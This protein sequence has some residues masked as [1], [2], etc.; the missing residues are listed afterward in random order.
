MWHRR[1]CHHQACPVTLI[2]ILT[3]L[4]QGIDGQYGE[5]VVGF[6]IF[7]PTSVT[8][9]RGLC[10]YIP[11]TFIIGASFEDKL[12]SSS[13]GIWYRDGS[14]VI[15]ATN[16]INKDVS[17]D[18]K[19]RFLLTGNVGK[20]DCSFSI[21]DAQWEDQRGYRFRLE[22]TGSLMFSFKG[23][24]P[25]V[26]VIELTEKPEI[27]NMTL[28]AG[29]MVTLSCTAPGTCNGTTPDITWVG[30]V[31]GVNNTYRVQ[32]PDGNNTFISNITFT[33]SVEDHNSLL[34]CT[35][36][37]RSLGYPTTNNTITLNVEYKPSIKI[38]IPGNSNETV[39]I[40]V[41]EG[42]SQSLQ[43]TVNSNPNSTII[44][45]KKDKEIK[46]IKSGQ[47]LSLVL[48]NISLSDA[49]VYSCT[50]EN[51]YGKVIKTITIAMEYAPRR[52]EIH[53]LNSNEESFNKNSTLDILEGSPLSLMCSANSN[54]LAEYQWLKYNQT[55]SIASKNSQLTISSV[56][57]H[58]KGLY[59]CE[60]TNKYGN[61]TSSI[62]IIVKYEG[63]NLGL[64][65]GVSCGAILIILLIILA[66]LITK[67]FRKRS[68]LAKEE[69]TKSLHMNEVIYSNT[70]L[71][72]DSAQR[73][74]MAAET[75]PNNLTT[76]QEEAPVYANFGDELQYVTLDF[77]KLKPKTDPTVDNNEETE[78]SEIKRK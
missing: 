18:T 76:T 42:D 59:T 50:A 16:N 13:T 17:S 40:I 15:V 35:V 10:V 45:M 77:S 41:K 33:P 38:T 23:K 61:A 69:M 25:F 51:K 44:W 5:D 14:E 26:N 30:R 36:T 2:F 55:M 70:N 8:V 9:Q 57:V 27:S 58:D 73:D 49:D 62:N 28:V 4:W 71:T 64:A 21:N 6:G 34:T 3:L 74:H 46:S 63:I 39:N 68:Q 78:Y 29:K 1:Y 56:S 53:T 54:P 60:A 66:V 65:I 11:C 43:C 67:Y 47:N 24:K 32:R 20:K 12:V 48:Q 31:N 37:Y 72:E 22:A 19:G 52:P 75:Q 7:A